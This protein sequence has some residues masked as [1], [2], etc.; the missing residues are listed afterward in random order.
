M[1]KVMIATYK[2]D[3]RHDAENNLLS[4]HT[5]IYWKEGTNTVSPIPA[6]TIFRDSIGNVIQ[7]NVMATIDT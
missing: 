2:Y 6:V 7:E 1:S 4:S 3:P 5:L